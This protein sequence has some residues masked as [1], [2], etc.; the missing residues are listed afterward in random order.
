MTGPQSP[1]GHWNAAYRTGGVEGV[2]WYE[3]V[4]T[5]SLELVASLGVDPAARVVDIGGGA[6]S[7]AA[8][9][10]AAGFA[11]VHVVDVSA[12]ALAEAQDRTAA[13]DGISWHLEDV[14]TW[15]PP[16][17]F[18]L[19]HDRAVFHFLTEDGD[20]QA[21][22]RTLRAALQPDGAV[23]I[24]TFAEDGPEYCSGLPVRRYRAEE[25]VE[26]LGDRFRVHT[27]RRSLHTTPAG[28]VQPFT[29]VAGRMAPSA[30]GGGAGRDRP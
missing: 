22:T 7:L 10:V 27:V 5:L 11:D 12:V 6:S 19:W 9:L 24:A 21:Y 14:R 1:A 4:P 15:Q 17:K 26:A 29:W 25:L 3:A 2:S 30:G 8:R 20:R 16:E 28:A 18:A 23:V 13:H